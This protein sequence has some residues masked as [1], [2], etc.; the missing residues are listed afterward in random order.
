MGVIPVAPSDNL[1]ERI[2]GLGPDFS[3]FAG[4]LDSFDS[5]AKV[6]PEQTPACPQLD[7]IAR[8]PTLCK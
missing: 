2:R 1:A 8:L 3:Q 6:F 4:K 7:I 5:V